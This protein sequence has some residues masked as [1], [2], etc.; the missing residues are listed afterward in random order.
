MTKSQ[1]KGLKFLNNEFK[2]K[3]TLIVSKDVKKLSN[4]ILNILHPNKFREKIAVTGTNGKT[5]VTDYT[6]QI[7]HKKKLIVLVLERL[8]F[9]SKINKLLKVV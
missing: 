7:W 6:R 8:V 1:T 3:I 9:F 4:E 2:K 5:S